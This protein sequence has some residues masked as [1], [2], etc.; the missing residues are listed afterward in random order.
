MKKRNLMIL[1]MAV[2]MAIGVLSPLTVVAST[3]IVYTNEVVNRD[4]LNATIADAESREHQNYWIFSWFDM[5]EELIRARN[6]RDNPD[7]TQAQVDTAE[8]RLQARIAALTVNR[9]V[10]NATIADAESREHQNYWIFSW[11]DMYDELRR[12]RNVR[13]NPNATQVQIDTAES[14]LR[15]KI[16]ALI[17]SSINRDVLNATIANAESR[18]LQNYCIFLWLDMYEELRRARNVRDNPNATQAQID[19]AESRLRARIAALTVCRIVLN[20][21]IADA[22]SR[23]LQNYFIFSWFDLQEELVRA[24]NTRDNQY[25]T[26]AQVNTATQRLQAAINALIPN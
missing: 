1:A 24:R 19:T 8:S 16:A 2:I 23:Q 9:D 5:Y 10:L 13:D 4:A 12:A 11:F 3:Q 22:E 26:Q 7:A 25:A 6:V 15:A 21:T 18:Q 20:A 17:L 14:R